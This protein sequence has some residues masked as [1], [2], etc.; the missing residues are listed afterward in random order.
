MTTMQL[1]KE[2]SSMPVEERTIIADSIL[3]TLNSPD[4][5][6]DSSWIILARSRL[7][8]MRSGTVKPVPG[9][10]VFEKIKKKYSL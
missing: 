9:D 6:I 2:V 1:I 3:R 4:K 5:D 7:S 10:H 8:E